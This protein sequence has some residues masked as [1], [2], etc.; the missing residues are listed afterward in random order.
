MMKA[1]RMDDDYLSLL[2]DLHKR[3]ERQGPGGET[4]TRKAM[5]LANIQN[6]GPL[7]IADIGCGTGSSTLQL[8]HSLNA[9][10]TAVDFVPAFIDGLKDH[11]EAEGLT[12]K[13]KPLVCPMEQLPFAEEEF[14]VIWSEGAIYNMGFEKGVNEW[15]RFIRTG[16]ILMVSEITWLTNTRPSKLQQYWE[17]QYP[18]IATASQKIKVLEQSGFS[19]IGFFVLPENCWLENYYRPLQQCFHDFLARHVRDEK[20]ASIVEAEKEEIALYEKYKSYYSYGVYVA[21]KIG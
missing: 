12:E 18:E 2:V 5:S 17:V 16:G 7:R 3:Q 6:S 9:E 21:Q 10:I 14:D 15:R 8:A 20:A 1:L 4:E 11:A 19:P 13:I